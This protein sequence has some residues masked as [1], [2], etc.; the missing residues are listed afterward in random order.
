MSNDERK[1]NF[2]K[3]LD[4]LQQ[5]TWQLELLISGFAIFGLVQSFE[6]IE[7]A[8]LKAIANEK[9]INQRLFSLLQGCVSIL[10]MV[11]ILHVILR[12]VWIGAVGLRYV[13]GDIDF[14]DL[15]YSQKFT[16]FLEKKVGPFDRYIERL[17][18][19]CSSLFALAFLMLFFYLSIFIF[20]FIYIA[21][22]NI[23]YSIDSIPNDKKIIINAV[24]QLFLGI[25]TIIYFI[26]FITGGIL[27]KNRLVAKVYFPIYR[28]FGFLTLAFL[29]RPLLYNFLDQKRGKWIALFTLPVLLIFSVFV[30]TFEKP[31]SNYIL[32]NQSTSSVYANKLN[33]ED[34]MLKDTDMVDYASI[35]SMVIDK[36]YVSLF[37]AYNNF[38]EDAVFWYDS[39]LAPKQDKRK[40]SF[41]LSKFASANPLQTLEPDSVTLAKQVNYLKVLNELYEIRIDSTAYGH[42]FVFTTNKND[43][44]G[45]KTILDLKYLERG[46]HA[47]HI[48]GPQMEEN[49]FI[50]DTTRTIPFWYFP[51]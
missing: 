17:E 5:E 12:G 34:Q 19:I 51:D 16:S 49:Q 4:L 2:K 48:V 22:L 32:E 27:K 41:N 36:P 45:F 33:Y 50:I 26:D 25:F 3:W 43:R 40:F 20:S 37:I 7:L 21:A 30:G 29:Y 8:H 15:K 9:L 24:I 47:L 39:I 6:P 31:K 18:N 46:K 35:S 11:L 42:E 38:K 10:T 13:S 28:F 1:L 23:L 14:D 44:L